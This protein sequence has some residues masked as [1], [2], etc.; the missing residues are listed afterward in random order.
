M[1]SAMSIPHDRRTKGSFIENLKIGTRAAIAFGTLL[2]LVLSLGALSL[3]NA[4]S[5]DASSVDIS[6]NWLPA[7]RYIGEMKYLQA[8]IRA[9][10]V[11]RLANSKDADTFAKNLEHIAE[12]RKEYDEV[13][14]KYEKTITGPEEAN[15]YEKVRNAVGIYRTEMD[16]G[17][18]VMKSGNLSGG[19]PVF[20]AKV[21]EFDAIINSLNNLLE[22]QINGADKAT[23]LSH[24]TYVNST[25]SALVAAGIAVLASILSYLMIARTVSKPITEISGLMGR[26]AK[27]D[28]DI[29]LSDTQR[30]DEVGQM[31]RTLVVFQKNALDK[32]KS[33]EAQSEARRDQEQTKAQAEARERA[34]RERQDVRSQ[35]VSKLIAGLE[36]D[37]SAV[38]AELDAAAS[39]MGSVAHDLTRIVASTSEISGTVAAAA[40]QA[41]ANV[42][43]VASATEEMSSSI[44]EIARQVSDSTT[45]TS[46]A[47]A[48]SERATDQINV[49]AVA[50]GKIGQIVAVISDVASKTDLLA[51]NA[52]IE[53]ARAGDSGKGFA[54]VAAE[55]KALAN[56]TAKA[57]D[58]IADQIRSIQEATG[59]TVSTIQTVSRTIQRVNAIVSSIAAA[60]EEQSSATSEISRNTQEAFAGTSEVS[61]RINDVAGMATQSGDAA[62]QVGTSASNLNNQAQKLKTS[63][64]QFITEVQRA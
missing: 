18:A 58:E 64:S 21:S 61:Q 38:F 6:E 22:F 54:V 45:V 43:T 3:I 51:L 56:Q 8:Q 52:T 33:D 39:Q 26:L 15:L 10:T 23:K 63:L 2:L 62:R 57:T 16:V 44:Q 19:L 20:I 37:T 40:Q 13:A 30:K 12:Y 35:T 14:K 11:G 32:I 29:R 53:A 41:T 9:V 34:E 42:Q 48:D 24:S 17:Y 4:R 50:A 55:V 60:I 28:L 49:L 36:R 47:V 46:E 31:A 27:G 1:Q 25:I 7:I 5:M 59:A